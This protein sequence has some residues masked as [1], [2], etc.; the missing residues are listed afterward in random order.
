M[1][2]GLNKPEPMDAEDFRALHK[3]NESSTSSEKI[4]MEG[5]SP[6]LSEEEK[7]KQ[8][9]LE[10]KASLF[11]LINDLFGELMKDG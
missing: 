9:L 7:R 10:K 2:D 3:L 6:T 8:A 4:P 1:T 11:E 5:G